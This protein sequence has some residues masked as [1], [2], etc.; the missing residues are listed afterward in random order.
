MRPIPALK[1]HQYEGSNAIGAQNTNKCLESQ[2]M[3]DLASKLWNAM[4][5]ALRCCN[6]MGGVDATIRWSAERRECIQ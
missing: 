4:L 5:V 1:G 2:R 6:V 3:R